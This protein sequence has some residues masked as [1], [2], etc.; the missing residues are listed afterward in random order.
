MNRKT[1]IIIAVLL[2]FDCAFEIFKLE[3]FGILTLYFAML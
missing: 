2:I 1:Y 3:D